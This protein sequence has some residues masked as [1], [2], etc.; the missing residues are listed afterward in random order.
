MLQ[1][2]ASRKLRAIP[3]LP[4]RRTK[5]PTEERAR[6]VIYMMGLRGINTARLRVIKC[7]N[8]VHYHLEYVK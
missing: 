2:D 8:C 4:C 6:Q 7:R 1:H 5:Y 3:S